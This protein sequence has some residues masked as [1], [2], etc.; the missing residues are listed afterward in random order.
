MQDEGCAQAYEP[1][2]GDVTDVYSDQP[3]EHV[4]QCVVYSTE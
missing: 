4:G 3:D 1:S 2:S